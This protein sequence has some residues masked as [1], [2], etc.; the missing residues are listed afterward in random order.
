MHF[1]TWYFHYISFLLSLPAL[2]FC[3]CSALCWAAFTPLAGAVTCLSQSP[4]LPC[5]RAG[6]S[7][8]CR[9]FPVQSQG[10]RPQPWQWWCHAWGARASVPGSSWHEPGCD[11]V[12]LVCAESQVCWSL[13]KMEISC[14][15]LGKNSD[16]SVVILSWPNPW[17]CFLKANLNSNW[18]KIWNWLKGWLFWDCLES[19]ILYS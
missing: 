6:A 9:K 11:K 8:S 10:E 12:V 13:Q 18:G 19:Q 15:S 4:A 2:P 7:H 1:F 3:L 16:V 14:V 5:S 17:Q